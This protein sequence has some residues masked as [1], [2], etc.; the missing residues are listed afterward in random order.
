[1][2]RSEEGKEQWQRPSRLPL[3]VAGSLSREKINEEKL[4]SV[5][6]HMK[7]REEKAEGSEAK[8]RLKFQG[9]TSHQCQITQSSQWGQEQK[10]GQW[11]CNLHVTGDFPES[12]RARWCGDYRFLVLSESGAFLGN[13]NGRKQRS[14]HHYLLWKIFWAFPDPQ[15]NLWGLCDAGGHIWL[16]EAHK[17]LR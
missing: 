16:M 10:T 12:N 5:Q 9:K 1:M 17:K 15:N 13:R 8:R 14:N 7:G 11:I 6:S 3:E 4:T 2:W